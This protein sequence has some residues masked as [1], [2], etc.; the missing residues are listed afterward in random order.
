MSNGHSRD[1]LKVVVVKQV[2]VVQRS[3][4]SKTEN[5]TPKWWSSLEGG[6]Y[7]DAALRNLAIFLSS[8]VTQ[9]PLQSK[10]YYFIEKIP[11]KPSTLD[12]I[13]FLEDELVEEDIFGD[14]KKRTSGEDQV[15]EMPIGSVF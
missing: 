14:S 5:G 2:V 10:S 12:V 9:S 15:P 4:Y 8:S 7:S 1:T 11:I 3:L 13:S 6:C